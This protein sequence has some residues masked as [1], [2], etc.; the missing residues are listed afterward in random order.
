MNQVVC[1]GIC[2]LV[3]LWRCQM[4]GSRK[5]TY[6]RT[7]SLA[8]KPVHCSVAPQRPT[9]RQQPHN[10]NWATRSLAERSAVSPHRHL[11]TIHT[12]TYRWNNSAAQVFLNRQCKETSHYERKRFD[13]DYN[14]DLC[15]M[16]ELCRQ[17]GI[18]GNAGYPY[19]APH[20]QEWA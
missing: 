14:S 16:A 5:R 9:S 8:L 10:E 2:C 6:L 4:D 7:T 20:Q 13:L 1:T 17:H 11:G 12:E 15:P 18:V 3:G 19:S